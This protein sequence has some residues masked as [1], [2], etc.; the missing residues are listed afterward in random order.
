MGIDATTVHALET[1]MRI[2]GDAAVLADNTRFDS[3]VWRDPRLLL[4]VTLVLASTV[5]GGFAVAAADH[6]VTY[7]ATSGA[8]RLGEPV[9]RTDL[10]AVRAKVPKRTASGLLQTSEA[11]PSRLD[12]LSWAAAARPGVLISRD[13][14]VQRGGAVELPIVVPVGNAPTDLRPGDRI[15]VWTAAVSRGEA[16]ASATNARRILSRV[17]VLDR[18][19]AGTVSG[20]SGLSIVVDVAGVKLSGQVV[21]AATSGR[22]TLVRVP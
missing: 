18:S 5:L 6:T 3:R 9:E 19:S 10:V 12:R 1:N 4:G 15:D 21:G 11:L 22:I 20:G 13:M 8:V 14:L 2:R 17:R 16:A 7:W